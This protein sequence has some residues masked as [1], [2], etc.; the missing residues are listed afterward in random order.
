MSTTTHTPAPYDQP[1]EE[2]D[3]RRVS[4][5][6]DDALGTLDATG[7]AAAI[8]AGSI[9]ATE[10]VEAAIARIAA[11]NPVLGATTVDDHERARSRASHLPA[12][13]SAPFAGVPSAFKD[14]VTVAGLPMRMG[15]DALPAGPNEV[16]GAFV[17]QYLSTGVIPV[18]TTTCPPFGWTATTERPQGRVTRN[19]WATGYS[20]GGSSGGSAALVASGAL[21]I[22]HGNDGGGS[23]RIPAAACGLVGLKA[24]RG[25]LLGDPT[26]DKTPIAIVVNGV[27]TRTVRDT[28]AFLAAA[29][30]FQPSGK[31]PPVGLV[32]GPGA[33]RLRIGMMLDSPLAPATDSQTREAV[34]GAARLLE[35]LG[36]TVDDSVQIAVP[37]FFKTD[38]EDYWGLLAM[39][40]AAQGKSLF[41]QD[42]DASQLDNVTL[43]LAARAKRR[44]HRIPLCVARLAATGIAS[45][46]L[47]P[48]GTDLV[49]TPTLTHTTP[50]IGYL[51]ADLDFETH[52]ERLTGYVGFTPLHNA[53]GQPSISL[54]LGRTDDGRPIG[55][56]LSARKGQERLLLE[57]AFELEAAAPL[58][59][60]GPG[61]LA[62]QDGA[63]ARIDGAAA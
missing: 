43:G 54:P 7:V 25:R 8:R 60:P 23:I 11:V 59:G 9:S 13:T 30:R 35:S 33:R 21:P 38:F 34:E 55:V 2:H 16:D 4:A 19:P 24:T 6:T 26:T 40:S 49:L 12:G 28:A 57:L 17:R 52:F 45:E 42:F 31:L 27:L 20:S 62:P 36:H 50:R 44:L 37:A 63:F 18:A 5:V 1:R 61:A 15:S 58:R 29:E 48:A 41:G 53:N 47:F 39:A 22:A 3:S 10:A 46:R 51:S 56:M 32:E 14:N